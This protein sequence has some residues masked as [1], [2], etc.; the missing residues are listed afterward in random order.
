MATAQQWIQ[1]ARPHTLPNAIAPVVAT[2]DLSEA[3]A[4]IASFGSALM[5]VVNTQTALATTQA[6]MMESI[7]ELTSGSN[8][9]ASG[10][11]FANQVKAKMTAF[12][13]YSGDGSKDSIRSWR[14][15]G[16]AKLRR[17]VEFFYTWAALPAHRRPDVLV[18]LDDMVRLARKSKMQ[19]S[20]P[21]LPGI[22]HNDAT[23]PTGTGGE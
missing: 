15:T 6:A 20:Q 13:T 4:M 10:R 22:P 14:T 11:S 17:E 18:R 1:G 21:T 2:Q 23:K 12:A 16:H 8:G 7:R 19:D 9:L 3:L 5:A